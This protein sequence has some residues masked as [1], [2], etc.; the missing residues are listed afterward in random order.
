[1]IKQLLS[2]LLILLLVTACSQVTSEKYTAKVEKIFSEISVSEEL[3]LYVE[4]SGQPADGHYTSNYQNGSLQADVTFRDGMISEGEIFT[5]EG[6]LTV[7]YTTEDGFMKTSYHT[8]SSSQPRMITLHDENLSDQVG[9]HTWDEDGTRRVKHDQTVMKQWYKN[10]QP[11][12]EMSLKDGKL[13][14]KS[15]R[16][17]KNG[18]IKSEKHYIN[19]VKDG[20]FKEWD[21]KG[22]LIKRQVYDMGELVAKK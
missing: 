15:A 4:E 12:F 20:T 3:D 18:Q 10:G 16:W 6:V 8:T 22:N 14:G 11:Q 19:N 1:M 9:F 13:H 7:R 5:S 17:Y 21:E 2:A